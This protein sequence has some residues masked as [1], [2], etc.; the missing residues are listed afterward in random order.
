MKSPKIQNKEYSGI[1]AVYL[2]VG[3]PQDLMSQVAN[4]PTV[5][6]KKKKHVNCIECFF[7]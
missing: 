6:T 4:L 7:C 2:L 3:T 1:I 5:Y